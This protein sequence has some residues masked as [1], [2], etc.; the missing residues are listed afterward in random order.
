MLLQPGLSPHC[1]LRWVIRARSGPDIANAKMPADKIGGGC[2]HVRDAAPYT[3][4][5][6][7]SASKLSTALHSILG[8]SSSSSSSSPTSPPPP[9]YHEV[10]PPSPPSTAPT[11]PQTLASDAS[12]IKSSISS[13]S[14]SGRIT[15]KWQTN[16]TNPS[17]PVKPVLTPRSSDDRVSTVDSIKNDQNVLTTLFPSSSPIHELASTSV[18]LSETWRGSILDNSATGLRT[19]YVM[20]ND[21]SS[22][23]VNLRDAVCDILEKAEEEFG[24]NGVVIALDKKTADLGELVHQLCYVGGT[25]T[26]QP[27]ASDPRYVLV[28]LD[29]M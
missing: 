29:L 15:N 25:I 9:A 22:N 6:S 3:Q 4:P 16:L 7:F 19:L 28:A 23:D 8:S 21:I 20:S 27:F 14:S 18:E 17:V 24:A 10:Y 1:A 11:S 2:T 26:N 5:V 13:S 12:S